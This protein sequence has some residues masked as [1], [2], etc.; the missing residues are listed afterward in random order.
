MV[1]LKLILTLLAIL[2]TVPSALAQ[3]AT[4]STTA[5]QPG[6]L[7]GPTPPLT[8]PIP[9]NP[10]GSPYTYRTSVCYSAYQQNVVPPSTALTF[11]LYPVHTTVYQP[12]FYQVT[13]VNEKIVAA[14]PIT[15]TSFTFMSPATYGAYYIRIM[16]P[17]VADPVFGNSYGAVRF[18]VVPTNARYVSPGAYFSNVPPQTPVSGTTTGLY[19]SD[20]A[21]VGALMGMHGILNTGPVRFKIPAGLTLLQAQ[22]YAN[23]YM[24]DLTADS[25]GGWTAMTVDSVRPHK[26]VIGFPDFANNAGEIANVTAVVAI[27]GTNFVYEGF[28]EPQGT[29]SPSVFNSINTAFYNAVKA[30]NA[31]ALVLSPGIVGF[32]LGG[33]VGGTNQAWLNSF[34]ALSPSL[35]AISV[36]N[37]NSV[38][39]ANMWVGDQSCAALLSILSANGFG[40]KQIWDTEYGSAQAIDQGPL[41]ARRHL[42]QTIHGVLQFERYGVPKERISYFYD[43]SNGFWGFP[44]FMASAQ[45]FVIGGADLLPAA[46]AFREL[47]ESLWGATFSSDVNMGSAADFLKVYQ[48]SNSGG[49]VTAVFTCASSSLPITISGAS[50][51][52]DVFGNPITLTANYP[53]SDLPIYVTSSSPLTISD[54]G[55]GLLTAT[56]VAIPATPTI[57]A[58]ATTDNMTVINDG[59]MHS[60]QYDPVSPFLAFGPYNDYINKVMPITPTITWG[61]AQTI[62]RIAVLFEKPYQNSCGPI[63]FNVQALISGTWTTIYTYSNPTTT[64]VPF[65]D[66]GTGTTYESAYNAE[67]IVHYKLPTPVSATA[68]R[69]NVTATTY[70]DCPNIDMYTLCAGSQGSQQHLTFNNIRAYSN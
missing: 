42:V 5:P 56:N 59:Q 69:V 16:G 41:F 3:G 39:G 35:D 53:L 12:S 58:G 8:Y 22:A 9:I 15:T 51:A 61:S 67:Y 70:G 66:Y 40:S 26:H 33:A 25:T 54:V 32:N 18:I 63:A 65:A 62:A 46:A 52:V 29:Y 2:L 6:Y 48:F 38:D 55:N 17:P 50:S 57:T 49:Y 19:P 64:S 4:G 60:G 37:Y 34:L 36:H 27:C 28:N 43:T 45:P 14:G 7:S 21:S 1:F 11:N 47:S 23:D 31:S 68:L 44:S 13:D 20:P 30:G 10:T 24:T